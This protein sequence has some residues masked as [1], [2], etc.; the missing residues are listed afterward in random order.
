MIPFSR[1]KE[2][3]LVQVVFGS[4]RAAVD[5]TRSF[6]VW[7]LGFRAEG[8]GLEVWGLG[9]RAQGLGGLGL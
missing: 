6:E 7:G 3:R 9:F 5:F 8:L 2:C 1:F 4:L